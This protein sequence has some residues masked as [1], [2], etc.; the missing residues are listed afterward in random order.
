M[1]LYPVHVAESASSC[2]R[3]GIANY[4]YLPRGGPSGV[5]EFDTG[6]GNVWID[7]AM[8]HFTDG[9]QQYDKDGEWGLRGTVDQAV[10]D[11]IL[12]MEYFTRPL[13]K[14]T[15][16]ELFGDKFAADLIAEMQANGR[17]KED[18]VA[19][20]TR[21]T[22]QSIL[23]AYKQHIPPHPQYPDQPELDEV[24]SLRPS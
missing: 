1:H 4:S 14:T 24:A 21:I 10:V 9:Q 2:V 15:G 12:G 18:C 6:P 23:V 22:A 3:G 8:R 11:R 17:S 16:R 5:F 7:Y 20:L 19:T 13:P